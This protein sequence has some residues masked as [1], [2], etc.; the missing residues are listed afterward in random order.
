MR[1][2]H[3]VDVGPHAVQRLLEALL[4][5]GYVLGDH[6]RDHDARLV[7]HGV[8]D[9]DAGRQLHAI[10]AQ[11]QQAETVDLLHLVGTDDVAGRDQLGQH[12]R[13][14]LQ[15]L[16]FLLVVLAAR[17]VLHHQD[18]EHAAC[19]HDRYA[20]QRVIDFLTRF[21][22]IG[23]LRVG[24]R[25]VQRQRPAVGGDVADQTLADPEPGAMHRRGV[26]ALGGKQFQHLAGAQQV[27]RADLGHHLVGDQA[28]DLGQRVLDG[29]G[30]RHR[31]PEPLEE[32]SRSG[33]WS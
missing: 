17:A 25:V 24:L 27:D 5:Q 26:E 21:G 31:V 22:A 28:H 19:A 13:D 10:D 20:G 16:D 23:E 15:G 8:A 6:P 30:T 1:L 33:R 14:S 9:R 11:R 2:E 32:H 4:L 12:H 7:Q 18:A 29:T 3:A